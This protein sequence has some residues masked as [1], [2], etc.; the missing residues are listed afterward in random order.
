MSAPFH[1]KRERFVANPVTDPVVVADVDERA[2][3]ALEQLREVQFGVRR[4]EVERGAEARVQLHVD[5]RA[6][7][8]CLV[9]AERALRGGLG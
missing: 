8:R 1:R 7:A 9:D 2:D 3:T 4:E 6:V 5:Q